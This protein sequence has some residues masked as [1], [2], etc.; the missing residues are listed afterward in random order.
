MVNHLASEDATH[1]KEIPT[2]KS[3]D[4]LIVPNQG[5]FH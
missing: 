3:L 5:E 1:P 2:S 4:E